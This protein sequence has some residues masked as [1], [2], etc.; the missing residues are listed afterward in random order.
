MADRVKVVAVRRIRKTL[1]GEVVEVSQRDA[2]V[3]IKAGIAKRYQ[4]APSAPKDAAP[5][6]A[7]PAAPAATPAPTPAVTPTAPVQ[8]PKPPVSTPEKPQSTPAPT[9]RRT[10]ARRDLKAEG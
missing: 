5:S 2:N 1:P 10:Y 3:L 9:T 7:R 8:A 6:P 4:P